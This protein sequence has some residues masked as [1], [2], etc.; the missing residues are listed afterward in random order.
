M[1][2]RCLGVASLIALFLEIPR[3]YSKK[4]SSTELKMF[5][6]LIPR[7]Y[8]SQQLLTFQ[9][10]KRAKLLLESKDQFMVTGSSSVNITRQ[11]CVDKQ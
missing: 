10:W 6:T 5:A 11:T 3:N 4:L 9:S 2:R 1:E 8:L 7:V